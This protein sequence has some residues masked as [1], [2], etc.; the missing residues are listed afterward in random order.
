MA[1]HDGEVRERNALAHRDAGRRK[2]RSL[3][4][5]P[6]ASRAARDR[7][8]LACGGATTS[9]GGAPLRL[10]GGSPHSQDRGGRRGETY[11]GSP[12]GRTLDAPGVA[13]SLDR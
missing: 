6:E 13:G 1:R 9:N 8:T 11:P 4:A 7:E 12:G 3:T 2:V 10:M 5:I